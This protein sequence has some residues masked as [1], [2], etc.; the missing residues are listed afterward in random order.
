[1][2]KHTKIFTT[3]WNDELILAQ[4]YQCFGCS[5]WEGCDIHHILSRGQGGSKCKDYIENLTCL[6]RKCHELC[7]KDKDYNKQVR[8]NT[9]RLIADRLEDDIR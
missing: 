6:C 8:V 1:M 5:S 4:S 9:L 3:F 2:Q 7:H